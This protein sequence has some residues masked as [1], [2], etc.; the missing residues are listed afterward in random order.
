[1]HMHGQRERVSNKQFDMSCNDIELLRNGQKYKTKAAQ[2]RIKESGIVESGEKMEIF[3]VRCWLVLNNTQSMRVGYLSLLL[4]L[5]P[6]KGR[7]GLQE[8]YRSTRVLTIYKN[9]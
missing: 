3:M 1:M 5:Q 9:N 2:R 7:Y 6:L 4:G 8:G